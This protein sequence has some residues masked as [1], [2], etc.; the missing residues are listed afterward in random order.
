MN[1]YE[2]RLNLLLFCFHSLSKAFSSLF[3]CVLTNVF[4]N[5]TNCNLKWAL[6]YHGFG[7]YHTFHWNLIRHLLTCKRNFAPLNGILVTYEHCKYST[8]CFF[9]HWLV[10]LYLLYLG[11]EQSLGVLLQYIQ[12]F[13][14]TLVWNTL[15]D[16]NSHTIRRA[17]LEVWGIFIVDLAYYGH[18]MT[19]TLNRFH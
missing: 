7:F 9:C 12:D 8:C 11:S 13:H 19:A 6:L 10:F 16:N 4:A 18:F 14:V 1:I 17:D 5:R 15:L 2:H 3:R